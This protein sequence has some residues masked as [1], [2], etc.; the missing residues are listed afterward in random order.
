MRNP[1][2]DRAVGNPKYAKSAAVLQVRSSKA[3]N[4]P[5]DNYERIKGCEV[6]ND[7]LQC[8]LPSCRFEDPRGFT[9][10]I[11]QV[12]GAMM[13]EDRES[14]TL[15]V[16]QLS[17]RYQYSYRTTLRLLKVQPQPMS[18]AEFQTLRRLVQER[19]QTGQPAQADK[20][21]LHS[22]AET[23]IARSQD[24]NVQKTRE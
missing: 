2:Y 11:Q 16:V 14:E 3:A 8:P 23:T 18:D 19:L 22:P 13:R 1:K 15:S 21:R 10:R 5:M 20:N 6:A 12:T 7:C 17:E 9:R 4:D 24:A